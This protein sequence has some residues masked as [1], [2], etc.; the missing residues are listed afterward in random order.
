MWLL[1]LLAVNIN[2]P[3][4]VPGRVSIEFESQQACER[5]QITV[6][7]WLKFDQFKVTTQCVK[8]FS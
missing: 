1:I 5:A 6:Q 8:K 7:S 3:K 2:N 4:D